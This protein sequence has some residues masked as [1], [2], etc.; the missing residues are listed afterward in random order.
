MPSHIAFFLKFLSVM[1]ETTYEPFCKKNVII[2][3]APRN[4]VIRFANS[5]VK[6]VLMEKFLQTK[7]ILID[8]NYLDLKM[9]EKNIKRLIKF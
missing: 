4:T 8:F 6:T 7:S 2:T 9:A 5:S 3:M 1:K